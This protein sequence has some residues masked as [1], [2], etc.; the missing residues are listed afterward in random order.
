MQCLIFFDSSG[1]DEFLLLHLY[2]LVQILRGAIL[3]ALFHQLALSGKLQN[4]VF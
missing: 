1:L 4:T 2:L 3:R